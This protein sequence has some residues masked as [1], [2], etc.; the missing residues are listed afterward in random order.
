MKTAFLILFT[1]FLT[2][3]GENGILGR[4]IRQPVDIPGSWSY[5]NPIVREYSVMGSSGC[6]FRIELPNGEELRY[7]NYGFTCE[8]TEGGYVKKVRVEYYY[9]LPSMGFL[10]YTF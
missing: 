3:C 5:N 1:L 4:E 9:T 10:V 2:A 7:Q 6:H 8:Y